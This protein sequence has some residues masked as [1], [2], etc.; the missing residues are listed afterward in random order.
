MLLVRRAW[1]NLLCYSVEM[2][3]DLDLSS[4]NMFSTKN[5][6]G[7]YPLSSTEKK[8][9]NLAPLPKERPQVAN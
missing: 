5:V 1:R 8:S 7:N 3:T 6:G 9:L 4:T 2:V